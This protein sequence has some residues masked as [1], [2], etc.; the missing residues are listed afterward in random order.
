VATGSGYLSN[1]RLVLEPT[2]LSRLE[3]EV[4]VVI[5]GSPASNNTLQ[6]R[7]AAQH[8]R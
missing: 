8:R 1:R 7:L 2:R 4:G 5:V 3:F 6:T